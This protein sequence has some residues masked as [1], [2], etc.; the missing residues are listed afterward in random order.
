LRPQALARVD[1]LVEECHA[2]ARPFGA[3]SEP[4]QA[5]AVWVRERAH[6]AAAGVKA[7]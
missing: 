4:L 3:R 2:L 6:A 5:L 7:E 1:Q